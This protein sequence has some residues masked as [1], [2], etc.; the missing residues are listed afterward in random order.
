M[1]GSDAL[2]AAS[3]LFG[4]MAG[5]V[6]NWA[7]QIKFLAGYDDALDVCSLLLFSKEL[8]HHCGRCLPPMLSE[9]S[10]VTC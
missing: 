5:T 1:Q 10:L 8:S 9:G 6:C 2:L 3:V 7:T 4:V